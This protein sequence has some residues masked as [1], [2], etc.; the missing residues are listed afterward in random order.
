MKRL[1]IAAVFL[2]GA[3]MM[4]GCTTG[5]YAQYDRPHPFGTDS[6]SQMKQHDVI[7]MSKA[8]VSDSL[9][10]SMINVTG[11]WFDITTKDV[12]R[13]KNA[14]VSDKVIHAMIGTNAPDTDRHRYYG[15]ADFYPYSYWYPYSWYSGFY[16]YWYYPSYYWGF[17]YYRPGVIH[18]FSYPHRTYYGGGFMRAPRSSGGSR[19]R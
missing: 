6:L 3:L 10:I 8:G 16:P 9:I 2:V 19:H 14:G 11:S 15:S 7:S 1:T 17:N 5:R 13:L 12:I 18:R 4:A